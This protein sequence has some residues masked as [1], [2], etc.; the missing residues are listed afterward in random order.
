ME[1]LILCSMPSETLSVAQH[2][3][4]AFF[5]NPRPGSREE[6]CRASKTRDSFR[7]ID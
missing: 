4:A 5:S 2:N 6:Y 7:V 1:Q 3:D